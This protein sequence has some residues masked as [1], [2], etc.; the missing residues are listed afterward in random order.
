[1]WP[2]LAW[3]RYSVCGSPFSSSVSCCKEKSVV[4]VSLTAPYLQTVA[5]FSVPDDISFGYY[6]VQ[7]T[8]ILSALHNIVLYLI[9]NSA[10]YII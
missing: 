1:M 2:G 10:L 7:L 3:N 8:H 4:R 6:A 5:Q 9:L